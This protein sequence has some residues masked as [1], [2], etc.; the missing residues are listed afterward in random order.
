MH[1]KKRP[2]AEVPELQLGPQLTAESKMSV[3]GDGAEGSSL[4]V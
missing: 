4:R 3:K 2:P 1:A